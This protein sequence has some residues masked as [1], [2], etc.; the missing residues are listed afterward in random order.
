MKNLLI[1][2]DPIPASFFDFGLFIFHNAKK[3]LSNNSGPYFYLPK[4]EHH[5]EA[6]L[7]NDIFNFSQDYLSIPRGSIKATVL[8]EHISLAFQMD[9]VLYELRNHSAGLNCGR[10]DYIFSYIKKFKIIL[11]FV[12]L[13][14]HK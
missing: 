5:L 10:W 2:N 1:D 3:L 12:C 6:R 8:V 7:W 4:L 11:I 9:E 14:V 13:I